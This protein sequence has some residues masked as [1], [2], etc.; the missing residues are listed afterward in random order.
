[1]NLFIRKKAY[2][3]M[4]RYN[5]LDDT[6]R[7]VYSVD[8]KLVRLLGRLEIRDRA[9]ILVLRIRKNFNPFFSIY[10]I[11]NDD[12]L[13]VVLKQSFRVRPFFRFDV[14][15]ETFTVTGN[16]R[17]CDFDIYNETDPVAS[18]RKRSL[19][20]GDTYILSVQNL[21]N[22]PV[23]CAMTICLDN[24]LFHLAAFTFGFSIRR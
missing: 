3:F 18:I 19:R 6:G 22:A 9:G 14:N 11:E 15:E 12:G 2:I 17:A 20:W 21:E 7:V 24:A 10:T 23:F 5:V 16:L 8:G 13:R 4:D 1:M